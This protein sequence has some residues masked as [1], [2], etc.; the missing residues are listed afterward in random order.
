M[1]QPCTMRMVSFRLLYIQA[2]QERSS[3]RVLCFDTKS[4]N[5]IIEVWPFSAKNRILLFMG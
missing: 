4:C 1:L 2:A 5:T 3:S